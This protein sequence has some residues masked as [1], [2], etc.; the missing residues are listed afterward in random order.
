MA[1]GN[2][3]NR[4][5]MFRGD[6]FHTGATGFGNSPDNSRMIQTFFFREKK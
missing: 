4:A 1:V 3:Y 2:V 6:A 5:V